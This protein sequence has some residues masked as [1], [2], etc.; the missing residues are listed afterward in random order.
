MTKKDTNNNLLIGV[1]I[2]MAIIIAVMWFFLGKMSA[3]NTT[4]NWNVEVNNY[5]SVNLKII[6][7]KR[8]SSFNGWGAIFG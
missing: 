7:D 6:T 8:D 5:E 2:F 3:W 4:N 1:I